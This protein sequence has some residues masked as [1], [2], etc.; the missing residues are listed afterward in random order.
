MEEII[1][2]TAFLPDGEQKKI[3]FME[4]LLDERWADGKLEYPK[5]IFSQVGDINH[6]LTAKQ[7]YEFLLRAVQKYPF[8]AV[9]RAAVRKV[10]AAVCAEPDWEAY[11]ADCYVTAKYQNQ[12]L[13]QGYFNLVVES[14]LEQAS[15]LPEPR[16]A[17]QWLETMISHGEP[18]YEIDDDTCPI[19]VYRQPELCYNT[20]KQFAD[21]LIDALRRRRQRVEVFEIGKEE[22]QSI[23]KYIG[24]RFKAVI[25]MQSYVFSIM[26]ED[27]KTNLHDLIIGPKYNMIFDHPIMMKSHLEHGPKNYYLLIHDRNYC[28]FSKKYYHNII[29][30]MYFPPAGKLPD[31]TASSAFERISKEYDVSFVGSY[32]NYRALLPEIY[33]FDASCRFLAARFM[34]RMKRCPNETAEQSLSSVLEA[35]ALKLER[36]E[37]LTLF[38]KMRYTYICIMSYYRE[39]IIRAI[40]D[41]GIEIHVYGATWKCA[42]F[43]DHPCLRRHLELSMEESMQVMQ[44]SKIT[45]NIMSWHKDGITERVLN[46]MLCQ[47][48]VVSDWSRRLEEEFMDGEEIVLFD[49]NQIERLPG[50]IENL[51]KDEERLQKISV[52]GYHKAAGRH[53]WKHR[54]EQFLKWINSER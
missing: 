27:Q 12:L 42:P 2:Y 37:F 15:Q 3:T 48:A 34:L 45:L 35:C 6:K 19:L 33:A 29:Q 40:L 8:K 26:M 5:S 4:L 1:C 46:G 53:L 51:L 22:D 18:Y 49:L 23:G 21:G 50:I 30:C 52:N 7:N 10:P 24:R 41:A 38:Y 39:K 14:L 43:A 44:R 54:A 11:R 31:V 25:G 16:E 36:E 47:T 13:E 32:T 9:G 20:L 28:D 17:R